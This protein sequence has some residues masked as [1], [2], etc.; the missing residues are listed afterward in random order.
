[1]VDLDLRMCVAFVM[2]QWIGGVDVGRC[3]DIVNAAY[4]SVAV[5]R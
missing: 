1:M 2:N 3:F 5:A 4:D